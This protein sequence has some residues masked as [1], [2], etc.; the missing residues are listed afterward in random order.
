[1]YSLEKTNALVGQWATDRGITINGNSI[2]Q[3]AK[4]LEEAGELASG[5]LKHRP[6][7][8]RDSIG[9][10]LVCL[11][12]IATLEGF[13]LE[14]CYAFAYDEIK[15]RKGYLDKNGNFLKEA[16]HARATASN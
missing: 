8:V 5:I 3:L 6:D 16:D 13:T 9:D 2:T 7:E 14:E 15:D 1:M 10:C 12:S 11:R 4:L